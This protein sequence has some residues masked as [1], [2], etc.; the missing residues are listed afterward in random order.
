MSQSLFEKSKARNWS[1][2]GLKSDLMSGT[3]IGKCSP[4]YS[5]VCDKPL[6]PSKSPPACR[7]LPRTNASQNILNKTST[8]TPTQVYMTHASFVRVKPLQGSANAR[9]MEMVL[10]QSDKDQFLKTSTKNLIDTLR[11]G[12]SMIQ[13]KKNESVCSF[14]DP[15][16]MRSSMVG[17]VLSKSNF[18]IYQL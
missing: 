11:K 16:E 8:E 13:E 12:A 10:D 7:P 6:N 3:P 18:R 14:P 5:A 17:H 9:L 2:V 1:K 4:L 15:N